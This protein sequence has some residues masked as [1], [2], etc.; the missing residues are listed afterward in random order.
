V[1]LKK[2]T[3]DES[4]KQF[5]SYVERTAA[6]VKDWPEWKLRNMDRPMRALAYL[7]VSTEEQILG[8]QAQNEAIRAYATFKGLDLQGTFTD[9]GVSGRHPLR[10]RPQGCAFY[11]RLRRGDHAVI[12]KLDR[13][14]R[15]ARDC[16]ATVE[17]W[18]ADGITLHIVDM[19][20]DLSSPMGKCFLTISAAF[21]EMERNMISVRTKEGLAATA[22]YL[23][24]VPFGWRRGPQGKLEADPGEVA[25]CRLIVGLSSKGHA[26]K[27]VPGI[28]QNLNITRRGK[29]W[30][31]KS[32][33]AILRRGLSFHE[34]DT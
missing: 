5:W 12:H 21:A 33:A 22:R 11:S 7:R 18:E 31:R 9:A 17:Q 3:T 20:L 4:G 30:N 28:L 25:T 10:Q 32:V 13:A 29:P 34:N 8:L 24:G 16:L 26:K 1:N 2:N 6:R 14:W 27:E 19:S 15:N 23:G